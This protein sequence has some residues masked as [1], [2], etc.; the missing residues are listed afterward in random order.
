M[1]GQRLADEIGE[2]IE[3]YEAEIERMRDVIREQDR[4]AKTTTV[5]GEIRMSKDGPVFIVTAA[6]SA[7]EERIMRAVFAGFA[8]VQWTGLAMAFEAMWPDESLRDLS[9]KLFDRSE[10]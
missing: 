1:D 10:E 3:W 5:R 9:E 8:A 7:L 4:R 6:D 2:K